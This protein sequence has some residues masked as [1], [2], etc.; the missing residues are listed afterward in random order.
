MVEQVRPVRY[1]IMIGL[2]GLLL[3]IGWA[4]WLVA[5]HE[6]IHRYLAQSAP[7]PAAQ[8]EPAGDMHAHAMGEMQFEGASGDPLMELAHTRL[9]RG[10]LH[11]MGLGLLTVAIS[12]VLMPTRAP[13]RIKSAVSILTGLGGLIYPVSWIAMGYRTVALG[14]AAAEASAGAIA[15][16]GILLVLGGIVATAFLLLRSGAKS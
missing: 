10:H 9:R 13:D 5:G 15:L 8:T 4:I 3:G 12:L 2:L 6:R 16:P 11:A 1:G 7:P 14:P